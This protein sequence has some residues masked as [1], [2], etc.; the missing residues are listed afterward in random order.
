MKKKPSTRTHLRKKVEQQESLLSKSLFLEKKI[1]EGIHIV[2]GIRKEAMN[3]GGVSKKSF[4]I[5]YDVFKKVVEMQA[6]VHKMN[7]KMDK[8]ARAEFIISREKLLKGV[9]K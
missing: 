2:E 3:M 1:Q 7:L 8:E 5:A 9:K 6:Q 4:L